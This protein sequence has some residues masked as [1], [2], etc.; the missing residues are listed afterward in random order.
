LG[1]FAALMLGISGGAPAEGNASVAEKAAA[2]GAS[3]QGL[4]LQTQGGLLTRAL[5]AAR[6]EADEWRA[7]LTRRRFDEAGEAN[8]FEPGA[9]EALAGRD[10]TVLDVNRALKMVILSG[11]ARQGMKP[12]MQF[13]AMRGASGIARVRI[14]D[15]RKTISGA[16]IEKLESGTYPERNDRLVMMRSQQ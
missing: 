9:P 10:L 16:V 2:A 4:R 11:G 15:V 13:M 14:V 5:A 1:L 6:A 8:G 12:G 7:E 3:E